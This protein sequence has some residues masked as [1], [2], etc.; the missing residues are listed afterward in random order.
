MSV[1]QLVQGVAVA[2]EDAVSLTRKGMQNKLQKT[3]SHFNLNCLINN[4]NGIQAAYSCTKLTL[5]LASRKQRQHSIQLQ[6]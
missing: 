1:R 6:F 2:H 3:Y 4:D 5:D